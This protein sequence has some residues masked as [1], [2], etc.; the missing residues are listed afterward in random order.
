LWLVLRALPLRNG[1]VS[2]FVRNSRIESWRGK[3][4]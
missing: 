2:E 4:I 1:S 3:F